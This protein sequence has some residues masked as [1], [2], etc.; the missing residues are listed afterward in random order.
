MTEFTKEQLRE[1]AA[2]RCDD[3]GR[4]AA[5]ALAMLERAENAEAERDRL[6][7][8]LEHRRSVMSRFP[9]CP[10]HRDKVAG[11]E[12]RE[13]EI[14]RLKEELAEAE[15]AIGH[16]DRVTIHPDDMKSEG[17]SD[18]TCAHVAEWFEMPAVRRALER[19]RRKGESGASS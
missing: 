6:K 10:D 1:I 11:L 9:F 4:L 16:I 15:E 12:C 2:I 8:E 18:G 17:H 7:G 14:E 5:F 19:G 13:C 3:A